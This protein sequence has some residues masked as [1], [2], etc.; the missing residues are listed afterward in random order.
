VPN[1][2]INQ[3]VRKYYG[4]S[5]TDPRDQPEYWATEPQRLTRPIGQQ[6]GGVFGFAAALGGIAALGY[7]P[8]GRRLRI[9]DRYVQGLRLFEEYSPGTIFR[10]F[11]LSHIFSPFETAVRQADLFVTP[12]LL[13]GNRRYAEYLARVIGERPGTYQKLISEGVTLR[14]GR[15]LWGAGPEVALPYATA[16]RAAEKGGATNIGAAYARRLGIRGFGLESF[17]KTATVREPGVTAAGAFRPGIFNPELLKGEGYAAQIIGGRTLQEHWGRRLGALGMEQMQRFNRLLRYLPFVGRRLAVQETTGLGMLGRFTAKF[18]LGLGALT[19]GYETLD[20]AA[21]RSDLLEGTLFEHGLTYG[22]ATIPVAAHIKAAELAEATGLQEF[23]RGQKEIAPG[24]T[25]LLRLAAFPFM[26]MAGTAAGIYGYKTW[27]MAA[28][29]ISEQISSSVARDRLD[30]KFKSWANMG[31]FFENLGRNRFLSKITP[32][33]ALLGA[34]AIAG[35]AFVAPFIP[36]ALIPEESPEELRRIYS[37]EQEVPIRKGRWW[38]FGRTPLEGQNIKYYRP[39]SYALLRLRGREKVI[40]GEEEE[41]LSPLEK[42]YRKEFTYELE[43]KHPYFPVTSLP[44]EDIPFVGPLLATTVGRWIKP[45]LYMRTDEWL[46]DKGVKLPGPRFGQRIVTEI[47][48]EPGGIPISPYSFLHT[49]GEEIYRIGTELPGLTGFTTAAIKEKLTGSQDWFDQLKLL[50][51]ARRIHGAERWYWEKELGEPLGFTEAFRRLYPHRRRQEELINPIPS[52]AP[53]WLPGPGEK[54]PDFS[55]G[56]I[57]SKVPMGE[58]RLPGPG[59]EALH[60]ELRGVE[61]EAYSLPWQF[62]ILADVAPYTEKY[63]RTLSK[64][65]GLRARGELSPAE[66]EMYQTTLKQVKSKKQ[67]VEF[68]EY[69]HLSAMGEIFPGARQ[70]SSELIA[71]MNEWKASREEKPSLFGRLFGGYWELLAHNA[72]TAWDQLTPIS[73]GAKLVHTRTAIEAYERDVLYG[74]PSAFWAHPLEHFIKPFGRLMGRAFGYEGVPEH[75]EHLRNIEEYFDIL[76]YV[77]FSR[78]SNLANMVG[79]TAAVKEFESKKDETLFGVSPFTRNY[80]A[81]YRALPR[82]ERDYFRA[83]EGAE[84]YEERVRILEMVPENEKALYLARWKL[85]HAQDL[86][87]AIK[88]GVLTEEEETEAQ[89]KIDEIY[90]EAR[91]EGFPTSKELFAEYT[92]TKYRGEN[93]ADWYRRTKLLPGV[94]AIPGADWC[95]PVGQ[96]VLT[97]SLEPRNVEEFFREDKVYQGSGE[98]KIAKKYIRLVDEDVYSISVENDNYHRIF[99][100]RGHSILVLRLPKCQYKRVVGYAPGANC[101]CVPRG[102]RMCQDCQYKMMDYV[103]KFIPIEEINPEIDYLAIRTLKPTGVNKIIDLAH[104]SECSTLKHDDSSVWIYYRDKDSRASICSRYIEID[105]DFCWLLGYYAAEGHLSFRKLP[106][107]VSF[108]QNINEVLFADKVEEIMAKYG[109]S[110]Q[111]SERSRDC[112]SARDL[113]IDNTPFA[114]L[115]FDLIPGGAKTKRLTDLSIFASYKH[116]EEF[117]IGLFGGDSLKDDSRARLEISSYRI[118]L[119][120]KELMLALGISCSFRKTSRGSYKVSFS[121][122]QIVNSSNIFDGINLCSRKRQKNTISKASMNGCFCVKDFAF[123]K[124]SEIKTEHYEGKVYNLG[125]ENLQEYRAVIGTYHNCGFHPSV[126]LED[127]KLRL[128]QEIGGDPIELN[129]WPSRARELPYKEFI[130]EEAIEPLLEPEKLTRED[131]QGRLN[132]L[133]FVDKMEGTSSFI[134]TRFDNKEETT[135]DIEIEEDRTDEVVQNLVKVLV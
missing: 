112:G 12:E 14:G 47:G 101:L 85:V 41:E 100:T 9:W 54:A 108:T 44:F 36:G 120:A 19:L 39:H 92:A 111:R 37:G 72:E 42:W 43:R 105:P 74:T 30:E 18:G 110:V 16:I 121:Y 27:K 38:M 102:N 2:F 89:E 32:Y 68:Q 67:R 132:E 34:G 15:L 127:V 84:T 55:T 135:V 116:I 20:W 22:L 80:T 29:Q 86:R 106:R 76:K 115:I 50:E 6:L 87:K 57:Y 103:P 70:E 51:S 7:A 81:L 24:S 17:F 49:I 66:E 82:R 97:E 3:F 21:R 123:F 128:I 130:D 90:D 35:L 96:K 53:F 52:D 134:T 122:S 88:A 46:S 78:L 33:Q 125:I 64:M 63:K 40:W 56:Y 118:A 79:D 129:L 99:A 133:F 91:A 23:A 71:T 83:F 31:K 109:L 45:E 11:Q 104:S 77:K 1:P 93:Y 8:A 95:L 5:L 60:P 13:A 119:L 48:Q 75:A 26:G 98:N 69:K 114:E 124:V 4:P 94:A 107:R 117:L 131:L 61:P 73:P 65:R 59:Y 10:T 25:D 62:K 113:R 126:D 58:I 28:L